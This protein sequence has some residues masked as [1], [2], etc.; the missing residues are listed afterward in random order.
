M[1]P[2]T[3]DVTNIRP[4]G[5]YRLR[6]VAKGLDISV[7]TLERAVKAG[8]LTAVRAG[9]HSFVTGRSLL[10][11]L[12]GGPNGKA[13]PNASRKQPL[14]LDTGQSTFGLSIPR[15][16]IPSPRAPRHR[17]A[18]FRL[19]AGRLWKCS[20]GP[21]TFGPFCDGYL[22][23]ALVRALVAPGPAPRATT[24]AAGNQ[25][26]FEV[27][28]RD[29]T[30]RT[31]AGS[32]AAPHLTSRLAATPGRLPLSGSCS[33]DGSGG[34]KCPAGVGDTSTTYPGWSARH[35]GCT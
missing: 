15:T 24:S 1:R 9:R 5:I 12:E 18:A 28:A 26:A 11:W 29:S 14:T 16:H 19:I 13:K 22:I 20:G 23:A 34:S 25:R 6:E 30:N 2:D 35:R 31:N 10:A 4:T 3:M 32:R 7:R 33:A 21:G 17:R 27:I 8:K